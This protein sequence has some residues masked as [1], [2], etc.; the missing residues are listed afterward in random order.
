MKRVLLSGWTTLVIVATIALVVASFLFPGRRNES[1]DAFVLFLGAIGLTLAVSATRAASPDVHEPSLSD[2]IDDP[3]DVPPE[4][5]RELERL[6]RE[7]YLSVGTSFYLHHRL[8]PVLREI[9]AHRL[10]TK[11]GVDL[12]RMPDAAHSLLG[13]QA[14]SWLRPDRAEPRDRW[15][16]GPPLSE[17]R[18]LVEALERI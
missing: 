17:L 11:H 12:D 6:E 5:P 4:R 10:L 3:L 18:G 13:D 2:R 15:A 16:P 7:V 8:R 14:W 9:A 1:L